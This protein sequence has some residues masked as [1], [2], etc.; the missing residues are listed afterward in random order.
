MIVETREI[1]GKLVREFFE[2]HSGESVS[3]TDLCSYIL[4]GEPNLLGGI[5]TPQLLDILLV[6]AQNGV[7]KFSYEDAILA[8]ISSPIRVVVQ[9]SSFRVI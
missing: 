3:F 7:I 2:T 9:C 6:A 4:K 8:T 5:W 1:L